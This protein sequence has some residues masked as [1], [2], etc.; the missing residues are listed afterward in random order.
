MDG[1]IVEVQ[2]KSGDNEDSNDDDDGVVI[3]VEIEADEE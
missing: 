3:E 2:D 1:T